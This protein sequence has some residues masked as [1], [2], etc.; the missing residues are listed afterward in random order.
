MEDKLVKVALF[1]ASG[2]VTM[3]A[4]KAVRYYKTQKDLYE[5]VEASAEDEK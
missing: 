5:E 1:I 4:V 3:K 2:V